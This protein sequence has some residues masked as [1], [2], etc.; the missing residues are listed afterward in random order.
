MVQGE[1]GLGG[2]RLEQAAARWAGIADLWLALPAI[3]IQ[4]DSGRKSRWGCMDSGPAFWAFVYV[5]GE[6]PEEE[7]AGCC[8]TQ[9]Q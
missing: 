2:C 3:V 7:M 9:A 6:V 1:G 5:V 8:R 4:G